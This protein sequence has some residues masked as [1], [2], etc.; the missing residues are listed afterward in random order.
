MRFRALLVVTVLGFGG[1]AFADGAAAK[2]SDGAVA[3]GELVEAYAPLQAVA[4]MPESGQ[5][6]L[7]NQNDKQYELGKIGGQVAG[8][9]IMAV[10]KTRVVVMNASGTDELPLVAAPTSLIAYAKAD[11]PV[12]K[13]VRK[14]PAT[15]ITAD[16]D[17][18]PQP[19]KPQP[20]ATAVTTET[21]AITRAELD[22]EL[23]DFDRLEAAID[24]KSV[25]GGGFAFT[26]V[27]AKSWVAQMGLRTGDVVKAVAGETVSTIDDAARVYARLRTM[28][29]FDIDL[30]RA[31]KRVTLHYD[32][33]PRVVTST[34]VEGPKRP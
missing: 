33:T 2:P 7:W 13:P 14:L 18:R 5:A 4:I 24:V 8:W 34:R 20:A 25:D 16:E 31:G 15:D 22:R 1:Q 11:A 29:S 28:A 9:K 6:L 10:E 32:V 26:R 21:H 23:G 19:E 17:P 27:D 12:A 30:D 3:D